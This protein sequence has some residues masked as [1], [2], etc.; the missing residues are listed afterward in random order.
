MLLYSVADWISTRLI[1][2]WLWLGKYHHVPLTSL[3]V[4]S[5]ESVSPAQQA[6]MSAGP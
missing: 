3:Y 6:C 5:S 4:D 1:A 2:W